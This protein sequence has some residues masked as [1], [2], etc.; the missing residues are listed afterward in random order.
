M[1]HKKQIVHVNRLKKAY[2]PEISKP[3]QE[4][5]TVKKWIIKKPTKSENQE[6]EDI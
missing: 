1:N 2:D 5:E 6:E 4:P 3:N